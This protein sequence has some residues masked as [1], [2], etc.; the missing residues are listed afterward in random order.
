MRINWCYGGSRPRDRVTRLGDCAWRRERISP[1]KLDT[2]AFPFTAPARPLAADHGGP[3]PL[4][5]ICKCC[6][7]ETLV[8]ETARGRWVYCPRCSGSF[9]VKRPRA[10]TDLFRPN[11]D[12]ATNSEITAFQIVTTCTFCGHDSLVADSAVG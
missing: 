12:A 7:R 3:M 10:E 11:G 2:S 8:P 6:S 4:L 5:A 1:T 9:A